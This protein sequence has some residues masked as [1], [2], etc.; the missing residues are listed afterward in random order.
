MI[1]MDTKNISF[2]IM[3]DYLYSK[4][5]NNNS[6]MLTTIDENLI[7]LPDDP[8]NW[9]LDQKKEV[10]NECIKNFWFFIREVLRVP[11]EENIKYNDPYVLYPK[12]T[13]RYDTLRLLY[14]YIN[15]RNI[16]YLAKGDYSFYEAVAIMLVYDYYI[17]GETKTNFET[18]FVVKDGLTIGDFN[19]IGIL[20]YIVPMIYRMKVAI[21]KLRVF[22]GLDLRKIFN[23][24]YSD[25][26]NINPDLVKN[27]YVFADGKLILNKDIP[28]KNQIVSLDHIFRNIESSDVT[29]DYIINTLFLNK[30]AN[31]SSD[32][33][34]FDL[35]L[36]TEF[37]KEDDDFIFITKSDK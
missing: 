13:I 32:F 33:N 16:M 27:K 1:D 30:L 15:N 34:F 20:T 10:Y 5:V 26:N 21:D 9:T 23:K 22:L 37:G 25:K 12:Y 4:D 18:P 17:L 24:T 11:T 14:A 7:N 28:Y 36:D 6:F 3:R 29:F 2:R 35:N 19:D 8:S 31:K